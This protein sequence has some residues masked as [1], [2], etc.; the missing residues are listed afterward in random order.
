MLR[1]HFVEAIQGF[2]AR[3]QHHNTQREDQKSGHF[4]I[5][6]L[7]ARVSKRGGVSVDEFSVGM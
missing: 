4:L 3:P 1:S 6:S 7:A 5:P 2:A